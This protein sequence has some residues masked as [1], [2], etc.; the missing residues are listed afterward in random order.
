RRRLANPESSV[1]GLC[2]AGPRVQVTR[3][4]A[5]Q[6]PATEEPTPDG[7]TSPSPPIVHGFEI[8]AELGHGGMG[9]VY[10]ARQTGLNRIVAL[11]MIASGAC[12]GPKERARFRA[13]AQAAAGLQ[14]ANIV[15]VYEV[16]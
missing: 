12:A 13:E 4:P 5:S 8:L 3:G 2:E 15:T 6:R 10:R 7:T 14:H 9:V 11:K 16:G 1:A